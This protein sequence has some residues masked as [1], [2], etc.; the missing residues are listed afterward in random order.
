[1]KDRFLSLLCTAGLV[2]A[3]VAVALPVSNALAAGCSGPTTPPPTGACTTVVDAGFT[4]CFG[5]GTCTA[6][7][8]QLRD[9]TAGGCPCRN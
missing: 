2:I 9:T 7:C 6:R 1:M 5:A 3:L 8:V 4:S